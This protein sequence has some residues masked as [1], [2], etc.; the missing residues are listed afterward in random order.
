M[1]ILAV[2]IPCVF[3]ARL[4]KSPSTGELF[5]LS[6]VLSGSPLE[7]ACSKPSLRSQEQG[8]AVRECLQP[9]L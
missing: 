9:P 5:G 3:R 2:P 6:H 4:V 1:S 7:D 8:L